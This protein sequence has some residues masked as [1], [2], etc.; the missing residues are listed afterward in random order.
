MVSGVSPIDLT[1]VRKRPGC[2]IS[3]V[4]LAFT[5]LTSKAHSVFTNHMEILLTSPPTIDKPI[6]SIL[7][8]IA[9]GVADWKATHTEEHVKQSVT[10][11]LDRERKQIVLKLL[12]F[13]ES[14][15]K[16]ELDHCNGRAGNSAA[17]DFLHTVQKEAIQAWMAGNIMP[18][19]DNKT[20]VALQK[21]A[22][23]EYNNALTQ[24]VKRLATVQAN[25]DAQ[26]LIKRI[27]A[28]NQLDN[29]IKAMNLI[30][31]NQIPT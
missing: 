26:E 27:V 7:P 13:N 9:A 11:M 10:D 25:T 14:W 8:F 16:W 20:Q 6:D 19:L 31:T 23:V 3:V 1:G 22:Q 28:S 29:Y 15:G 24:A 18:I 5:S 30:D 4:L 21:S 17:G 2:L 12:G